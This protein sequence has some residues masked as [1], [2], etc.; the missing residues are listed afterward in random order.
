[1]NTTTNPTTTELS[2]NESTMPYHWTICHVKSYCWNR[3]SHFFSPD[4][5]RFFSSRIQ[6]TPPYKGR[7]FVTSERMNWNS[8]RLYTVRVVQP[9]GNIQTIGDFGA[10][11]SRQSAHRFA[12]KYA[13]ENFVRVGNESVCLPVETKM[14]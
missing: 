2:M 7:V 13:A 8:P 3:G 4:T 9:S 11:T 10:F 12:E 6:T 1:M 14:V 5:M